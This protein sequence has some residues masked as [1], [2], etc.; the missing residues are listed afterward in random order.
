MVQCLGSLGHGQALLLQLLLHPPDPAGNKS[1]LP[2]PSRWDA[3]CFHFF[4]A[5]FQHRF[6]PRSAG[7]LQS[8]KAGRRAVA[9]L[10][11]AALPIRDLR[12]RIGFAGLSKGL[13][14]SASV[15]C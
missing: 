14:S 13:V 2:S 1:A 8:C 7:C 5:Y 12:C 11:P 4:R 3:L 10:S 6:A 9:A 15:P